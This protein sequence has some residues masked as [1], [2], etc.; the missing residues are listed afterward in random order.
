MQPRAAT[1][2]TAPDP[3][4]PLRRA[5]AL[6]QVLWLWTSP[7]FWGGLRR[8]HVSRGSGPLLPTVESSGA[9]MCPMASDLASLPGRASVLPHVLH[10]SVGREPQE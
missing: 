3:V 5:P 9:A 6:P 1:H 10:L 7:P 8:C 4:S 2:P